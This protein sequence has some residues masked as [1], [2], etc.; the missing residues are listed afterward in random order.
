MNSDL[1]ILL[2]GCFVAFSCAQDCDNAA[3]MWEETDSEG[4]C[5]KLCDDDESCTKWSFADGRC[6]MIRD[7]DLDLEW[8]DKKCWDK[9]SDAL[10]EKYDGSVNT[11]TSGITCQAWASHNS[12]QTQ[13][14]DKRGFQA[15][16]ESLPQSR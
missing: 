10:G 15:S 8:T 4:D 9:E 13:Y 14:E 2:L 16:G 6:T 3:A 7:Q 5:T 11:T 12:P 1:V